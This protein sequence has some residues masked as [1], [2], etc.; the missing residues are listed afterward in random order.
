MD[1][2][3]AP[4]RF[5]QQ[6]AEVGVLDI[7]QAHR[8][9]LAE[10]AH[11]SAG[12]IE[13]TLIGV[14]GDVDHSAAATVRFGT[15]EDVHVNGF[16][17]HRLHDLRAGDE[18]ASLRSQDHQVG[19]SRAVGGATGGRAKH[20]GNLRNLARGACHRGEDA[21]HRVQTQHALAQPRS[22]GVPD[23]NDGNRI[24]ERAGVGGDNGAAAVVAHGAALD[25]RVGG[26][27]DARSTGHLADPDEDSAVVIGSD[28]FEDAVV[29][30][31]A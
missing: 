20:D 24:G 2:V 5:G 22:T 21:T 4:G 6:C 25:R 14:G 19:K 26:E 3:S 17:G 15:T 7:F 30:E 31:H 11:E 27:G 9:L 28:E 29:E 23:A 16:T 13:G 12:L 18:D 10:Q 8:T 1:V